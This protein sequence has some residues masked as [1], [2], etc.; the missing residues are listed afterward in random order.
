MAKLDIMNKL[1][2][3]CIFFIAALLQACAATAVPQAAKTPAHAAKAQAAKA[4]ARPARAHAVPKKHAAKQ[5]PAWK[6]TWAALAQ[7]L[8]TDG[9]DP[10]FVRT[11]FARLDRAPSTLPMGTKVK[12]LYSNHF[13]PKPPKPPVT[14]FETELGIPGPWFRGVVTT[15]NAHLCRDFIDANAEA[16]ALAELETGVPQ[17][18]AAALLF[19]ETRLGDFLGK[20][21]AFFMLASMAV[22]RAPEDVRKYLDKLPGAY[23]HLDWIRQ[24]MEVKADWAYK[25]LK[26]LLEYCRANAI[27]PIPIKG[28]VYGAIGLCQFMPSNIAKLGKDGDRDGR[29]DLFTVSDAVASLS[30]Y[31]RSS[32]WKDDLPLD[33]KIKV[34]RSYNAM[35]IYA[36]TI[37]AL[38]ETIV[39]LD[40]LD[41]AEEQAEGQPAKQAP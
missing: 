4:P 31:L 10:A 37:L 7:Q 32:G 23:D 11:V 33:R 29:I 40:E 39:R 34:L 35:N 3:L 13:L 15:H 9:V 36:R 20:E 5:A 28:S 27:D 8:K 21:N 18:V 19:V 25:E 14:T 1:L 24:K 17:E 41:A 12:E 22:T 6:S 38:A 16:F 26:A 30:N 2:V